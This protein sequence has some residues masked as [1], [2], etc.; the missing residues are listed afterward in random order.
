MASLI[1]HSL[2]KP[3]LVVRPMLSIFRASLS[4]VGV[5]PITLPSN[6]I[7]APTKSYFFE[8]RFLTTEIDE[9]EVNEVVEDSDENANVVIEN[10][11]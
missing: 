8:R 4:S 1:G 10:D 11:W 7:V 9:E 2:R 6:S 3:K 5:R